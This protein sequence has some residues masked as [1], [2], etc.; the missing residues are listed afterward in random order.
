M[1]CETV[2]ELIA[3][4]RG[5]DPMVVSH[6]AVCPGCRLEAERTAALGR[7]LSDPLLWETPPPELE[8]RVVA[9]VAGERHPPPSR[10]R[11]WILGAAALL[12][13]V[14]GV[15]AFLGGRP[16][17]TIELVGVDSAPTA[18]ATV[19]GWNQDEGTRMV[20][21]IEGLTA[22]GSE[23]YYEVWL[24]APDGRHVSAGTFQTAGRVEVTAGV[25][26]ADFPRIWIT[27]EPAD[28]DPAPFPDTVL[29]TPGY[30]G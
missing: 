8:H 6:L 26:R 2:L 13:A 10:R 22:A 3:R 14:V 20:F 7:H 1:S 27:R 24:T 15:A 19:R 29:D 9:A 17:W 11:W 25:R 4:G 12:F 28:A 30:A 5:D 21:E 16:D 18:Q 23:A